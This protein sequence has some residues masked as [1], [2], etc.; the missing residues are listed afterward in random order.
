M[1]DCRDAGCGGSFDSCGGGGIANTCGCTRK[2]CMD[3]TRTCGESID[4]CGGRISCGE[5]A[6]DAGT[7]G[8]AGFA[9]TCGS[10]PLSATAVCS[11]ACWCWSDPL[12]SG[13]ALGAMFG[14]ASE[15]WLFTAGGTFSHGGANGF[16]GVTTPTAATPRNAWAASATEL[17]AV[18]SDGGTPLLR[19]EGTEWSVEP[20][21]TL[22]PLTGVWGAG[23][24]VWAVGSFGT[25]LH[26]QDG[27]W[28][29]EGDGGVGVFDDVWA[30]S[31]SDVWAVGQ[32]G[33]TSTAR[34]GARPSPSAA[35]S[36]CTAPRATTCGRWIFPGCCTSTARAG[37]AASTRPRGCAASGRSRA[38]TS[39]RSAR[40]AARC[41]G[42]A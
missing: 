13:A 42:T 23:G 7:C 25:L 41:T 36:T 19:F 3:V 21:P 38:T 6:A 18:F 4:G 11:E 31:P 27:G 30:S 34:A 40:R 22:E 5:C 9:G 12:P 24:E 17:Y 33:G 35:S 26:K 29:S 32:S 28:S 20:V 2:S 16:H 10:C 14:T 39:G 1:R 15:L 37:G 8:G